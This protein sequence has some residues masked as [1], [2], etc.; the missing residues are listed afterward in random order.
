MSLTIELPPDLEQ[1]LRQEA[2]HKGKSV[3]EYVL[4]ALEAQL[5]AERLERNRGAVALMKQWL[6]EPPNEED[7]RWPEIQAA[8]EANRAGQRRLFDA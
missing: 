8:L 4:S 2:S 5:E 1:R 3:T 7:E 6:A